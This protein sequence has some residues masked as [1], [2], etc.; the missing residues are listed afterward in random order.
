MGFNGSMTLTANQLL[1]LLISRAKL[2]IIKL[3]LSA[4]LLYITNRLQPTKLLG[5]TTLLN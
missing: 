2:K 5:I 1:I 4:N 3:V